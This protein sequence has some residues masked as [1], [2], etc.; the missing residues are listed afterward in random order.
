MTK[1]VL[2]ALA[3]AI[4]WYFLRKPPRTAGRRDALAEARA[5]LGVQDGADVEAIRAA[6]RR[7]MA[8]VHPDQGGTQELAR[9]VNTAR[10]LLISHL[11]H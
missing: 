2:V 7:L 11:Q 1:L 5:L 9:K 8:R 3:V 10:D 6:H 4:A